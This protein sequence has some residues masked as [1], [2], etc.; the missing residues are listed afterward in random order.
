MA[1]RWWALVR[2]G[3]R[4]LYN[5]MAWTYDAVSAVVSLGQW[6]CWGRAA[7]RHLPASGGRLLELAH[8]T[9][10]LQ[11]DLHAA[12]WHS[13]GC[14]L[15]P[16]MGH[17][18]Q[19]KLARQGIPARL[20]RGKAQELPFPS[21]AFAAVVSTFPTDFILAPATLREVH[22]VLRPGGRFIIVPTAV[23]TGGSIG[24][25]FIEW[26]YRITGQRPETAFDAL[27]ALF[28][29][30]GLHAQVVV[31]ECPGSRAWV[32]VAVRP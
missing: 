9:G 14:D 3:F 28:A 8:G 20:V 5:E 17:I 11:A 1:K 23:L 13:T 6:R 27:Q 31:E 10:S 18:A 19:R 15:S 29:A 16:Y 25:R 12:G 22:R 21:G 7:L 4:L 30:H 32:I 2:F 26:L 24:V